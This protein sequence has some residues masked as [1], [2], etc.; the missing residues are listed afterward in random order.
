MSDEQGGEARLL[1][2]GEP[3]TGQVAFVV[4]NLDATVRTWVD[5][6]IGP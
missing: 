4:A 3:P 1:P 6:G 5:L 2:V